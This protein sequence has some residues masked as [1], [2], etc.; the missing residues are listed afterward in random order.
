MANAKRQWEKRKRAIKAIRNTNGKRRRRGGKWGRRRMRL[1]RTPLPLFAPPFLRYKRIPRCG[2]E[3]P[4]STSPPTPLFCTAHYTARQCPPPF[5][6]FLNG[7]S[8]P[9]R[10]DANPASEGRG[11]LTSLR[12]RSSRLEGDLPRGKKR[13]VEGSPT[14]FLSPGWS[15]YYQPSSGGLYSSTVLLEALQAF[16]PMRK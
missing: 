9:R 10:E 2:G 11:A 6:H 13:R 14:F 15:T 5:S 3:C 12:R 7:P 8:N 1:R 4:L 16:I